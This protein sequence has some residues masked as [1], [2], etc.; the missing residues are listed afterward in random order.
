VEAAGQRAV[1]TVRALEPL[2]RVF[3]AEPA[4]DVAKARLFYIVQ[5]M[6]DGVHLECVVGPTAAVGVR[7][8]HAD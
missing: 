2:L 4:I 3:P 5:S 6:P 8:A 7:H 1:N